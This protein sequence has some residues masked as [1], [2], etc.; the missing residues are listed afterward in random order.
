MLMELQDDDN[1][2]LEQGRLSV[3]KMSTGWGSKRMMSTGWGRRRMV[4]ARQGS[5]EKE[6]VAWRSLANWGGCSLLAGCV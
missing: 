6:T 4:P 1:P 2:L 3:R 5:V